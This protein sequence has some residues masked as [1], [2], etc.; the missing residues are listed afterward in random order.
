MCVRIYNFSVDYTFTNARTGGRDRP[1]GSLPRTVPHDPQDPMR[2]LRKFESFY[3]PDRSHFLLLLSSRTRREV[4]SHTLL[5]PRVAK[6][7]VLPPTVPNTLRLIRGQRTDPIWPCLPTHGHTHT[8]TRNDHRARRPVTD[9]P[10]IASHSGRVTLSGP[11]PISGSS[12]CALGSRRLRAWP[13]TE[14]IP[15]R[16]PSPGRAARRAQHSWP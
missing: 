7:T 8:H 2:R 9:A 16:R 14:Q 1:L 3:T 11:K 4:L 15:G 5:A 12:S 10:R 13:Q 6:L